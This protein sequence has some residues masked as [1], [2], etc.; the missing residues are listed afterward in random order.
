MAVPKKKVS[1]RRR[2][3][4]RS[5][6]SSILQLIACKACGSMKKLHYACKNCGVK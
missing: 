4:R 2:R 5:I 3:I 1:L 6:T